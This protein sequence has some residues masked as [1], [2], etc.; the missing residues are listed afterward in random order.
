MMTDTKVKGMSFSPDM[1][2]FGNPADAF[3]E[4]TA[5]SRAMQEIKRSILRKLLRR[6]NKHDSLAA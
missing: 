6:L 4:D 3:R 1:F 2:L 5:A